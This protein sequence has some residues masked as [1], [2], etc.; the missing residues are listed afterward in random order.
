MIKT[1][2]IKMLS[3]ARKYIIFQVFWQ[4]VALIAQIVLMYSI[5]HLLWGVL[6]SVTY[7]D[8]VMRSFTGGI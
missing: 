6:C 3:H 2:L 8:A 1:R 7:G 5:T 4:W